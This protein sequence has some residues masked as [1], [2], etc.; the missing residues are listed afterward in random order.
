MSDARAAS[1]EANS[2]NL[3]EMNYRL[4]LVFTKT[5][6][7]AGAASVFSEGKRKSSGLKTFLSQRK[8]PVAK[9]PLARGLKTFL[10]Q[11][12]APVA[13]KPLASISSVA[14]RF[15]DVLVTNENACRQE[16]TGAWF[17]D[18]LVT[19]E[20]TCRQEA[21]GLYLVSCSLVWRRSCHKGKHLLPRS[22]WPL[23]RQL[24][25]S[26]MHFQVVRQFGKQWRL[27]FGLNGVVSRRVRK[28]AESFVVSV[29]LSAWNNSLRLDGFWWNLTVQNFSKT[30][31]ENSNFTKIRQNNGYF[32]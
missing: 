8:T 5:G 20:S 14:A 16:A 27:A 2:E 22:H 29:L 31:R 13:K 25:L 17:E 15:E 4:S 21:T 24:Q 12:K 23:S 7:F 10:S 26:C 19:K 28:I 30:C 32:T 11:R 3:T 6:W 9:K 18:V 1:A